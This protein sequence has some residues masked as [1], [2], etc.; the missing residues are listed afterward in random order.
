[1]E[2]LEINYEIYSISVSYLPS[3]FRTVLL[4]LPVAYGNLPFPYRDKVFAQQHY[5]G[6]LNRMEKIIP[7]VAMVATFQTST[8]CGL[9]IW[10]KIGMYDFTVHDCTQNKTVAHTFL[11]LLDNANSDLCQE[12]LFRSRNCATM[13][14]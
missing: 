8:N 4:R 10:Q 11:P 14:M 13:V 7:H 3:V 12:R 9:Q 6:R 1:M 5:K 2:P